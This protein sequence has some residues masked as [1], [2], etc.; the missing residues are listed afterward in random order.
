MFLVLSKI[1]LF[2]VLSFYAIKLGILPFMFVWILA[3]LAYI[4]SNMNREMYIS[5]KPLSAS[6]HY[7]Q[8]DASPLVRTEI[9]IGQ[10]FGIVSKLNNS[11]EL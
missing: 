1:E 10:P 4:M 3:M 5:T 6:S 2:V 7:R 11:I 9:H 8:I